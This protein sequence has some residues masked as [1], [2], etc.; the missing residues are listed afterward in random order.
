MAHG[1]WL[2]FVEATVVS[3]LHSLCILVETS[4]V[5]AS[6]QKQNN[7][8]QQAATASPFDLDADSFSDMELLP[9]AP[10]HPP[11]PAT[12]PRYGIGFSTTEYN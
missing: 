1:H 8:A 7:M 11:Q 6:Q 12:Q 9:F 10:P 4:I 2:K 3:A 5:F